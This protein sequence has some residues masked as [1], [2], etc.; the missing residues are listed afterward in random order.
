MRVPSIMSIMQK[1]FLEN[2][3]PP[4]SN[5]LAKTPPK[6]RFSEIFSV[7]ASPI[8]MIFFKFVNDADV[9]ESI[10]SIKS[11]ATGI[12]EIDPIFLNFYQIIKILLR[13]VE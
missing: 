2:I 3:E 13:R 11:N 9:V 10:I 1:K 4:I 7:L 5:T 6:N 8:F 12:D